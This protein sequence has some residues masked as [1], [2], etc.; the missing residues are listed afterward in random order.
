MY[1]GKPIAGSMFMFSDDYA[2]YHLSGRD[3]EYS[4]FAA[5]N[6]ILWYAIRKAKERG[7]KW[8][9][10]GGGTTGNEDDSLLK[11]KKEFS[12]TETEFWIGKR[13]HNREIYDTIVAQWKEK[14]PESYNA[15][16]AMLLGYRDI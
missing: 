10:F 8:F 4:R 1:D 2:H 7:C 14:Y 15:H 16:K 6:L 3:R 13:V 9:H 5:N 12:K 11:F